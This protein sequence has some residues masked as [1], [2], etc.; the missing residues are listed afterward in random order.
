MKLVA[1]KFR[2]MFSSNYETNNTAL[3]CTKTSTKHASWTIF[4]LSLYNDRTIDDGKATRL[5]YWKNVV[6]DCKQNYWRLLQEIASGDVI[7]N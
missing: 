5:I 3:F 6:T 1:W 4:V 7:L 2:G